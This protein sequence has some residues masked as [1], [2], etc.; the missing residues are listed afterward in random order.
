MTHLALCVWIL[1][2]TTK[3][4]A[5]SAFQSS[6]QA[7]HKTSS[8]CSTYTDVDQPSSSLATDGNLNRDIKALESWAQGQGVSKGNGFVLS[9]NNIGDWSV[10][11]TDAG[12]SGELVLQI[13]SSLVLSS[14]VIREEKE[15]FDNSSAAIEFLKSNKLDSQVDQFL[16]WLKVLREYEKGEESKF[17][18][19]LSSLPRTFSNAICMDEV[20][21]DCL[22]P[23]AWS[24]AKIEILHKDKFIEALQLTK[25]I[26][27]QE[28]KENYN[29][30]RW[31]FNVV[32]SRCWGQDGDED[33]DRLDIVPMGDMF[34]HAHPANVFIDYDEDRNCNIILKED[35]KPGD[36]LNLSY[37]FPFNPYRFLVVFGFVDESLETIYS[38]LLSAKPSKRHVDMGYD[39]SKMT[40]NVTDGSFTEEVWDFVLY[41]LLEQVPTIQ[42]AYYEAHISGNQDGKDSI[43][44]KYYLETCIML[45]KHVD[46][47]LL[48]MEDLIKKI[49]EHNMDEHE[50]LPMIRRNNVFVARVFSKVKYNVDNMIQEELMARK[51]EEKEQQ[52]SKGTEL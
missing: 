23:F 41:S 20:E 10:S 45:K 49:D 29:L 51:A 2:S 6:E 15:I 32:F 28:T 16:L 52:R 1:I 35:V 33:E 19:W 21:L 8:R 47:T 46:N 38:Q 31:A 11:V 12:R 18:P 34:N 37:G 42:D 26:V 5:L 39:V 44:R 17:H 27:S 50:I 48:E 13:P 22:A 9:E 40:F 43:R 36:A 3:I 4:T 24:L 30:L 14:A 25:G 7:S